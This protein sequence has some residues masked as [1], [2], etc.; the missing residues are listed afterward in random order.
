MDYLDVLQKQWF[1]K[2]GDFW[3]NTK[4]DWLGI[5]LAAVQ[6]LL[7]SDLGELSARFIADILLAA[8]NL[9][10]LYDVSL[11]DIVKE[12]NDSFKIETDDLKD[13][14]TY[15]QATLIAR[16]NARFWK[17]Q[18]ENLKESSLDYYQSQALKTAE[19]PDDLDYVGTIMLRTLGL[20]GEGGEVAELVKKAVR[21]DTLFDYEQLALE[22]G[23]VLWYVAVLAYELGYSLSRVAEMNRKKLLERHGDTKEVEH[24]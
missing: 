3:D 13:V 1:D 4:S 5:T 21:D 8:S 16:G 10:Y 23:D 7:D 24:D 19:L 20:V 2:S 6:N 12:I 14:D 22:L 15:K 18:F 9:A 17:E 11:S